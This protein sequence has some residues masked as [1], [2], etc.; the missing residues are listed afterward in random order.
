MSVAAADRWSEAPSKAETME[1]C[2]SS[3]LPARALVAAVAVRGPRRLYVLGGS[4]GPSPIPIASVAS[5]GGSVVTVPPAL[6]R[7]TLTCPVTTGRSLTWKGCGGSF[8]CTQL[9][10]PLDYAKPGGK[11]IRLAVIRLKASGKRLGLPA[12][13][14]GRPRRLRRRL[15]PGGAARSSASRCARRSTSS[16]STRAASATAP[17]SDCLSGT[18]LD[19]LLR[20]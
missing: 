3:R 14:P 9:T 4:S 1:Q 12:G 7:P 6:R 13:Q 19:A 18:Q 2:D 20:R 11:D 5:S 17:R 10:V 15:R 8:E 16:A